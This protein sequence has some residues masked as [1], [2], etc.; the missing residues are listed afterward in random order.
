[1]LDE[2]HA[3]LSGVRLDMDYSWEIVN[4]VYIPTK[5]RSSFHLMNEH[6]D[7]VN[8][9]MKNR[10][11]TTGEDGKFKTA[12]L[13]P[14]AYSIVATCTG[15]QPLYLNRIT[16]EDEKETN[17]EIV[18]T[19]SL[20][21]A[22]LVTGPTGAP[23]EQVTIQLEKYDPSAKPMQPDPVMRSMANIPGIQSRQDMA[24]LIGKVRDVK[25]TGLVDRNELPPPV[26]MLKRQPVITT[27]ADGKFEFD[28]LETGGIP[29]FCPVDCYRR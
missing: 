20:K 23:Q 4:N 29:D 22:G 3:P 6:A 2:N 26:R 15:Y 5:G 14:D 8:P 17:Q 9:G 18:L 1:M 19:P 10:V 27:K 11:M 13:V 12:R 25:Q 28:Q 7:L 24:D 21:I 16:V